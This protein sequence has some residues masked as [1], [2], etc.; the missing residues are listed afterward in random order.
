MSYNKTNTYQYA[1]QVFENLSLMED[2][3]LPIPDEHKAIFRK[4]LWERIRRQQSSNRYASRQ[5]GD[6]L[7]VIRIQ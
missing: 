1:K 4:H 2:I 3:V 5:I 7:K 6:K